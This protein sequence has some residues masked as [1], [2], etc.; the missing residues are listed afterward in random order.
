MFLAFSDTF[1]NN[2]VWLYVYVPVILLFAFISPHLKRIII[3]NLDND[4]YVILRRVKVFSS[5]MAV[6]AV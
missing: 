6:R 2:S 3:L 1:L 5:L 4:C